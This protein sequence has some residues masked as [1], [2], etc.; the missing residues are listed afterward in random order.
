M[1][2]S[3]AEPDRDEARLAEIVF[4]N[5]T[6][7]YG[8]MFGGVAYAMMDRAAF[9]VANG[10]ARCNAVTAS[11]EHVDFSVPIRQ[12]EIVEAVARV[13]YT[14]RSSI[15][16]RVDLNARA[17]LVRDWRRCTS[18]LFTMVAVDDNGTPVEIPLFEPRT[19]AE[20]AAWEIARQVRE[21]ARQ[22]RT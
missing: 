20:R 19:D 4:P 7:P 9:L 15:V 14:G 6:N 13:I 2:S 5:D 8:T 18:G 3:Q 10:Y 1:M 21:A 17:P 11:S 22:R 16:V 12:G